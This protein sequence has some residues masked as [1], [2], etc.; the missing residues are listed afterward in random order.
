MLNFEFPKAFQGLGNLGTRFS[1]SVTPISGLPHATLK[2]PC[3]PRG[4]P[5]PV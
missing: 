1:A 3:G 2:S 4:S 5:L